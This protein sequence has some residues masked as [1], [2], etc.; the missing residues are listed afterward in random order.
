MHVLVVMCIYQ[1]TKLQVPNFTDTT[2]VT[3]GTILKKNGSSN[4]CSMMEPAMLTEERGVEDAERCL[5]ENQMS[6]DLSGLS[7]SPLTQNQWWS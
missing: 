4:G 1:H 5:M 2:D 7:A 3:G 6:S